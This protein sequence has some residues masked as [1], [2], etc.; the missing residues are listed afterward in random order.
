MYRRR[1]LSRLEAPEQLDQAVKLVTVPGWLI[2]AALLIAVAGAAGW[3]TFATVARTVSASGVITHS[4]GVSP[5][6]AVIGGQINRVWVT[7]DQ[8]VRK[9]TPLYRVVDSAGQATV[10]RSPWD[11]EVTTWLAREGQVLSPGQ[12]VGEFVRL[13]TP[14]DKLQATV[15]LLAGD[16]SLVHP[17]SPVQLEAD[18]APASVFGTLHGDVTSVGRFPQTEQS[19][20]AF[21]GDTVDV[22]Q[23]LAAGSVVAVTIKLAPDAS[24]PS[25]LMWSKA[26]PPFALNSLS[27]VTAR[28]TVAQEH[29]ISWLAP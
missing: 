20:T 1:A 19:L 21:L 3:A 7:A 15:Y 9:G 5:L 11:A 18:A 12:Q 6:D 28:F 17:G 2:T 29:P 27:H 22:R 24:A 8:Q 23:L 26:G 16:A 25:G 14:G 4:A 13:D 10:V